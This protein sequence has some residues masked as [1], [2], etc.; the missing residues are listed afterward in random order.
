[1]EKS[2][3]MDVNRLD[4]LEERVKVLEVRLESLEDNVEL[5]DC[6]DVVEVLSGDQEKNDEKIELLEERVAVLK[7]QNIELRDH[8][9]S[10]VDMVNTITGL[11]NKMDIK[12]EITDTSPRF[13]LQQVYDM[14]QTQPSAEE[15]WQ[16]MTDA[17]KAAEEYEA[18][19]R[20]KRMAEEREE[21][22]PDPPPNY[23]SKKTDPTSG[24]SQ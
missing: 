10:V 4:R 5:T 19:Q 16:E 1:M 8:L 6:Q 20:T 17:I 14:Y 7:V 15:G 24:S 13:T 21:F 22:D 18:E 23:K 11:L 12:E 9:N 2:Q 3:E